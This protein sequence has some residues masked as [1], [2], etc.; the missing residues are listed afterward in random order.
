[1]ENR[2]LRCR[3]QD[4]QWWDMTPLFSLVR[5][6]R[7]T[8]SGDTGFPVIPLSRMQAW[9]LPAHGGSNG[10]KRQEEQEAEGSIRCDVGDRAERSRDRHWRIG[11]LGGGATGSGR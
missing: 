2:S 3:D 9:R 6:V 4:L 1:M 7:E 5:G 8:M 10:R 11:A